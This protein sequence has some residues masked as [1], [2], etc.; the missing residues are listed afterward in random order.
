MIQAQSLRVRMMLLFCLVV[1]VLLSGT[2]LVTYSVF[3]REVRA[4]LDRRLWEVANP[5]VA[6]MI[7]NPKEQQDISKLD[8]PGDFVELVDQSGRILIQSKNLQGRSLEL[9]LM[10]PPNSDPVYRTI[11][12]NSKRR[13]RTSI[14][15]FRMLDKSVALVVA[16]STAD[17]EFVLG[18]FRKILIVL[19]TLSLSL[20]ALTSAWYVR[21]S[22]RPIIELTR[23]AAELTRKISEAGQQQ[24]NPTLTVRHPRDELGR[25]STT[26]NKL[27][28]TVTSA[29]NQLR[30]F[31]SD[32]S[33]ELRTPLSVLQGETEL[34]LAESRSPE[35]Y[36]KAL[37]VIDTELKTLSRIVAGLFTLS[38]A[39]AGQLRLGKELVYLDEVVEE[40]CEI[41]VPLARP[42]RISIRR[43]LDR[44]FTVIGDETF[45]REL[46]LI[47]LEN[48][49]KYSP[50]HTQVD[51]SLKRA[52]GFAQ[53]IFKDQGIG[54]S[55]E[56]LPHI[57]E[58]F[59]RAVGPDTG[60][61][62]SGGLGLAIAQAIVKAHGGSIVC[63]T[64]KGRG[65]EFTVR[66]PFHAGA[67][68]SDAFPGSPAYAED[69]RQDA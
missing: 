42:K 54:I 2:S 14:V 44:E 13:L 57:F 1:A 20:M 11:V 60:G 8:I 43:A 9:G 68:R 47:F 32:A 27:F 62:K 41:A 40:A 65:S 4:Q 5:M 63:E 17:T 39:D 55:E 49:V 64:V 33:H 26:F 66:L 36:Q 69:A 53:L 24:L 50:S 19:L 18:N 30:Q 38:M 31:V 67:R 23:H 37:R 35:E 52:G 28:V 56:D 6:E 58:R 46:C 59:F 7:D 22:L 16:E 48:A 3:S 29:L 10:P 34:L 12:D 61:A 21:R 25:L 15:P 45:L 51:V